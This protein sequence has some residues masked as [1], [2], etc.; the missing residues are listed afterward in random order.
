MDAHRFIPFKFVCNTGAPYYLYVSAKVEA[1]LNKYNRI[2]SCDLGKYISTLDGTKGAVRK[3]PPSN[4]PGNIM[5]LPLSERFELKL[6]ED[7]F[8]FANPSKYY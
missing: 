3:T 6:T 1:I 2:E 5:G 4:Q 8:V 7:G